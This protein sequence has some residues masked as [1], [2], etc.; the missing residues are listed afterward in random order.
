MYFL[1]IRKVHLL[2]NELYRYQN[3]PCNDKIQVTINFK[4]K[5]CCPTAGNESKLL[6]GSGAP[7]IS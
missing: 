6:S 1:K 2:V 4:S 3:S 7:L 5:Q